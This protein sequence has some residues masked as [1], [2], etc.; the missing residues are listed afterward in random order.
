MWLSG[1]YKGKEEIKQEFQS[2]E[3]DLTSSYDAIDPQ[4]VKELE[5]E[6]LSETTVAPIQEPDK[7]EEKAQTQEAQETIETP[8]AGSGAGRRKAD[9]FG[10]KK[11]RRYDPK[12]AGGDGKPSGTA[13][14]FR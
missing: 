10:W 14:F 9:G 5:P 2:K 4:S 11:H 13:D 12:T 1:I 6:N 7:K 8:G 3:D